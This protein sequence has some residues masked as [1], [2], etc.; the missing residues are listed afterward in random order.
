MGK[1]YTVPR[2]VKGES[3]ILYIFSVKSIIMIVCCGL[4]GFL[5]GQLVAMIGFGTKGLIV[6][7]AI[8]AVIGWGLGE[9]SIPDT[10]IV[11]NLRKA[12]GEPI[13]SILIRTITFKKRK[14]IYI[15]RCGGKK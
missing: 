8:F 11:G 6:C 7:T 5:I 3:R 13:L 1:T 10:P 14:K 12:G 9:L 15:Y 2:N 4:V